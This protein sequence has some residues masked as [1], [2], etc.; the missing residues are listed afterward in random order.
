MTKPVQ[1]AEVD[2]VEA[3]RLSDS[4]EVL[5]LDVREDDEWDSGHARS[6]HTRW[7]T[8]IVLAVAGVPASLFG[9][10]LNRLVEQDVL[11]LAFA[12][13]M[14]V[15]ATG[16][17][18][19][20]RSHHDPADSADRVEP[21]SGGAPPSSSGG[22]ATTVRPAHVAQATGA[23][24][25]L[26]LASIGLLIGLLTGFLGV[27]GGFVIVPALV[28]VLRFPML[29]AVGTSLLVISLNAAV[30]LAARAGHGSFDWDVIVPFTAA[31][32]IG[33]LLGKKASDRSPADTLTRA[34]AILLVLV[35]GYVAVRAGMGL[36]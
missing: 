13:V 22:T 4:G 24:A 1:V 8:G 35:A 18:L 34:F 25:W 28:I 7:G 26:R 17:L 10:R 32:V 9:T 16:M 27:G 30:A 19:R 29:V 15:A 31:A 5:L 21:A 33:S 12:A 6:G 36:P 2:A 11:L 20:S 23:A 14:L 3:A